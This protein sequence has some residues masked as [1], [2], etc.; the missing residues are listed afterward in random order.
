M[1][2]VF[3]VL[4][5]L[6]AVMVVIFL[7]IRF[8]FGGPEDTWI[9]QSGQWVKHGNPTIPTPIT[10]CTSVSMIVNFAECAA[11]GYPIMESYPEQ[12]RTPDGRTFVRE[13]TPEEQSKLKAPGA[14]SQQSLEN[15]SG[16]CAVCPP[17]PECSS[18]ACQ[19]QSKC[20]A[21]GFAADWY[22]NTQQPGDVAP[23]SDEP[24][25]KNVCG[26]GI[27]QEVV[28]MAVGCPCAESQVTC[29]QDC[30]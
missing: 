5:L 2:K 25:C 12:C 16:D 11:A 22:R 7:G 30:K 10:P 20:E 4:L 9:C 15:C 19:E 17:C 3:Q 8:F 14:C 26:D 18:I 28:C 13:L 23:G 6:L 29:P 21:M 24:A 1:K 27:C